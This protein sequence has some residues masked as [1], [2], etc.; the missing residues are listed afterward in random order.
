LKAAIL[1]KPGKIIL[2]ER[3]NRP[4]A[5]GEVEIAVRFVAIC[6]SDQARFAGRLGRGRPVVFGHEFSGR[7]SRVG[8][9]VSGFAAS[10]PVTAAPL[11]NCG[12][13]RFC[14]EGHE[15]LCPKRQIFGSQVDGALQERVCI[16]A[17]RVFPLP[18][19]V[20]LRDGALTEPLAVAVHAVRQAG[21]IDGRYVAVLGAGA[22]GLFIAQVARVMGASEILTL[23]IDSRRLGLAEKMGFDVVN[24]Q[25][26]DPV[27]S[28]LTRTGGRGVDVLFEATGSPAVARYFLPLLAALGV[29]VVVGRVEQPVPLDLDAMLLKEARLVTSRYFSLADFRSGVDLLAA[30]SV[31]VDPLIQKVMPFDLLG[32]NQGRCVMDA[33][34]Q[35]VRLLIEFAG[36]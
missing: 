5:H 36:R 17:D 32:E 13:C 7:V 12:T 31:S 18:N 9:G 20:S 24:S 21:Q 28:V 30:G 15:Y 8:A 34:R 33:A 19:C 2:E 23:D 3:R 29:I 11:L 10:Q 4:P 6:G 35:V 16:R 14:R 1:T 27:E 22:I 26:S 25:V